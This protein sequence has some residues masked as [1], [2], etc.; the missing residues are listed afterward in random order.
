MSILAVARKDFKS[1]RRSRG[2]WVVVTVSAV[3]FGLISY[4]YSGFQL[5]AT[6][7]V[8][9]LFGILG[10]LLA[11]GLPIV[12][13]V[14]SY[15]AIAGEREGGGVKF[16]L[17]FPN[18]RRDVYLGKLGSRIAILSIGTL[19]VFAAA[20]SAAVAKNG[21]LPLQVVLGT[22]VLSLLYGWVFVG[23]AVSFSAVVTARSRAI[24]AS[25]GAYFVLVI[26]YV[27]PLVRIATIV[28]WLH[29]TILGFDP[30]P[31]LY[32]AVT[33]TSPFIAF[34]KATNLVMPAQFD[35]Q[36]F[37][38]SA[39]AGTDLPVYLTDEFSLVVFAAWLVVP[40]ALGLWRFQRSDLL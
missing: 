11:I 34:R 3:L 21:V 38:R 25:V 31:N 6:E 9:Q 2:L 15:M 19:F 13:M 14:T 23:I 20:T 8:Q 7:T 30:N 12:A 22:F 37:R 18:T 36:I 32:S 4:V 35:Q 17:S 28:R 40:L 33:Y 1:V 29:T 26:A 27:V 5:T 10:I 39:Q 24:A 16:L